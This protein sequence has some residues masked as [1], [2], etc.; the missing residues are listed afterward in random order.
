MTDAREQHASITLA[1]DLAAIENQE[2]TNQP[3]EDQ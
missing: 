1:D 3:Q 2:A